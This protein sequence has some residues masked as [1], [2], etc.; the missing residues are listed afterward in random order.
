MDGLD[1]LFDMCHNINIMSTN[2]IFDKCMQKCFMPYTV[3]K[4]KVIASRCNEKY[5]EP[6][7]LITCFR[8]VDFLLAK[9]RI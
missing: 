1:G 2:N 9:R 7:G 8:L 3:E 6:L 4:S 5:F